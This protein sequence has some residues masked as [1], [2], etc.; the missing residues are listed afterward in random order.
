MSEP[1][2]PSP[3]RILSG[4][5]VLLA[6]TAG[7]V[8]LIQWTEPEPA[9]E[10]AVKRT[11]M[12][13][14]VLTAELGTYTP[15]IP[16][17]GVVRPAE[18]V[19]LQ[20]R[21]SGQVSSL[22]AGFVP[23]QVVEKGATLV[24]LERV[25][26]V[27]VVD[28]ARSDLALAQANLEMEQGR[29]AVARIERDHIQEQISLAQERLVLREPQL[30]A[31]QASVEAAQARLRQAELSLSRTRVSAPSRSLVL[32]RLVG[33][34]SLVTPSTVVGRLVAVERFWVELS[35]PSRLLQFLPPDTTVRLQDRS[36]WAAGSYREGRLSGVVRALDEQTR[37]A[38]LLVE[39]EDPLA[40]ER[41]GPALSI[42]AFVQAELQA[43]TLHEVTR[44]PSGLVRRDDVVWTMEDEVLR[45]RPVEVLL[46]DGTYSYLRGLAPGVQVVRTD[47][48]SVA[49]GAPLR[50]APESGP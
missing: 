8:V 24:Q 18:D 17:L 46:S 34:G 26:A 33:V 5:L 44:L 45:L 25:D 37:M 43:T 35:L 3:R 12:L 31:A 13:V 4:S 15:R 22:G 32:S 23:G 6:L 21:V 20:A 39:V 50:V 28:L 30:Q 1:A 41:E 14:E 19:D 9:R 16:A 49:D 48:A 36:A 2:A 27:N 7:I 10:A 47:L 42:G 38:R 11:P 40:L 29:Q